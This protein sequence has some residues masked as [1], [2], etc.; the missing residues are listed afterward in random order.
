MPEQIVVIL[1]IALTMNSFFIGYL[2]GQLS[3]ANGVTNNSPKSFFKQQDANNKEI[4]PIS[5]DNKKFVTE[6][7]TDDLEKKYDSLG[8]IKSTP[9]NISDSV[10]KLKNLKK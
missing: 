6:I 8:D 7:R 9:E 1:I 5:I 4:R 2:F 3:K 10:N